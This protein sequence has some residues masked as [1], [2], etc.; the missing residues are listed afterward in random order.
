[1]GELRGMPGFLR[2]ASFWLTSIAWL[3]STVGLTLTRRLKQR[4]SL[5]MLLCV[6]ALAPQVQAA[7]GEGPVGSGYKGADYWRSVTQGDAGYSTNKAPE[8][9]V[10]INRSGEQ[11]RQLRNNLVKRYGKWVLA[12]T[13]LGLLVVYVLVGKS[14]LEEARTGVTIERWK[15]LDRY[16]HWLVA[17]LFIILGLTGLS[18]LFGRHFMPDLI[19]KALFNDGMQVAKWVHNYLGPLFVLSLAVMIL[20]WLKNNFI[21]RVDLRWF[22]QGG[23]MIKGKHPHAGYMNGGEKLWFWLLV[24]AGIVVSLSGLV[25]DFPAYFELRHDFQLANLFHGVASLVLV[26][27]ALAHAYIG[28]IGT[29]GALEGMVSGQVDE[30]WAKQHHDLWYDEVKKAQNDKK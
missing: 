17:G 27:G 15:R 16:I 19:G 8:A 30:A 26:C 5:C 7:G 12:A 28:S 2:G 22:M 11:W 13:L 6:I 14:R 18:L 20:K 23:G 25:L 24:L 1:M 29:E 9:G 21:T 4:L 3:R 10:L